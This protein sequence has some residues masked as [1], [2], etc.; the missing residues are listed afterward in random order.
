LHEL[1]IISKAF[2][3]PPFVAFQDSVASTMVLRFEPKRLAEASYSEEAIPKIHADGSGLASVLAHLK[4][5][6]D[7]VFGEIKLVLKQIV[8]AVRRI[9]IERAVVEQTAIRTIALD[10]QRH[11]VP[12]KRKLWGDQVVLDMKGAKGVPA[13]AAGDGAIMALAL[14]AI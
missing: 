12:E 9:R 7:E 5:S 1:G 8:P 2:S 3:N 6:Q 10:E 14:L 11:Q 13:S 4:L